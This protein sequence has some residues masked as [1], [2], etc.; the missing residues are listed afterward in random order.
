[1]EILAD[2][3]PIHIKETSALVIGCYQNESIDENFFSKELNIEIKNNL[4]TFNKKFGVFSEFPT[5]SRISSKRILFVGL[6]KRIDFSKDKSRIISGKIVVYCKEHSINDFSIVP[7]SNHD[8]LRS[9]VE[10]IILSSYSFSQ[11]KTKFKEDEEIHYKLNH[12]SIM[13]D[14][15]QKNISDDLI[16]K[17]KKISEAV[18]FC[19]DISN[20]P[21]NKCTPS[22][23]A[24]VAKELSQ[25]N[26]SLKTTIIDHK[27]M[28]SKNMNGILSVGKGSS[29][30]PKLIL[31]EYK[32]TNSSNKKPILL[33]GKAVTFDSGGI[34]LK[35]SQNMD[36][37]KFDK[38]GGVNVLA[39][40]KA[41]S[42]LDINTHVIGVIPSVENMPSENS[43]R[44]SDII[45]M[46]NGINVEVLNTDAEGRMILADALAYSINLYK[47]KT[48]IDMATLTGA[49]I[50]ALGCNVAGIMGN[51]R[52]LIKNLIHVSKN[53]DEHLWELPLYD[54]Y[55]K[56]IKSDVADIK[57]IGGR[58]G[59]AITAAAFL[60]NFVDNVPWVH[61]DIAGT[62][63]I[64][65]ATISKSYNPPGATGF[66]VRTI[67]EY[68]INNND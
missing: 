34:S 16:T 50:I 58:Q 46:Y 24:N 11:L 52:N 19:R 59:G 4:N 10:G 55:H 26:S 48:V 68:I 65:D 64:Q 8:Y 36:E 32:N 22:F 51:D 61:I 53:T 62:A 23:L 13:I 5:F 54:E 47:P 1:M 33:V 40:M 43:Y 3:T 12:V 44:P 25:Q 27:E 17:A 30:Q 14:S 15:S 31:V 6:G 67:I 45:T 2:T 7:F 9:I 28:I 57:N 56:Q 35:P 63:W 49:C 41:L 39:I 18:N 38:C 20:L 37:M 66:G 29:N 60:S 21:P 42:V